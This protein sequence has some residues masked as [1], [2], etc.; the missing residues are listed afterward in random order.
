MTHSKKLKSANLTRRTVLKGFGSVAA[1]SMLPLSAWSQQNGAKLRIAQIGVSGQGASNLGSLLRL[2]NAQVVALCDVDSGRLAGALAKCP[3]AKTYRDYRVLFDE[4][5]DEIDAVLV[6]TPDHM[7]GPIA[8]AAMQLGKHVYSEKPL[9][10]NVIE[11]RKLSLMAAK[12]G[13]VTQTG[14]QLSSSIGQRMTVEYIR[15]GVIGKVREVHVWSNKQWGS[16]AIEMTTPISE[17]PENL[18]WNL[19]LGVCEERPYRAG[20][21]HPGKWR[22]LIDFGTG[23]LGDMGVHIFDTPY[24]AL[25]L[26]APLHVRSQCREPSKVYHPNSMKTEYIFP[27]TRYTANR[28]KWTWY[29]GQS[30]PP[31]EIP[32]LELEPGQE[33]PSQGCVMIGDKG[34]LLMPHG[35]GPR[36]FPKELIRSVPRP[37]LERMS[38]HGSWVDACLGEG[39]TI[40][41]FSYG[42]PL[43]EALQLG[44]V[45]GRFPGKALA[46]DARSMRI[47]NLKEANQYLGRSYRTNY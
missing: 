43:C 40:A 35:A 24:R 21:Y 33:L 16:S 41:P 22:R 29:D 7:H 32:G 39:E 11:N 17:A 14:I 26:T 28:L 8:M 37:K 19:W 47:T 45:A 44:V 2:P 6:S 31:S 20:E 42:G 4:M 12:T 38:H 10:H 9:A 18:D 5:A 30:A 27:P 34:A 1:L 15:S 3:T 13:V 25:G 36:T 46:W 23:T